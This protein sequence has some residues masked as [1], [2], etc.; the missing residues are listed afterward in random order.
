VA[1]KKNCE[2]L[3]QVSARMYEW[4][5]RCALPRLYSSEDSSLRSP[6]HRWIVCCTRAQR[7]VV[8]NGAPRSMRPTPISH[9]RAR[10]SVGTGPTGPPP[11]APPAYVNP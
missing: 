5:Q 4:G 11:G 9:H 1:R 10:L 2:F 8:P 7:S 6:N 3:I